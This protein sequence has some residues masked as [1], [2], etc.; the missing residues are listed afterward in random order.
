MNRKGE[1]GLAIIVMAF[2][3]ILVGVILF[4]A[5]EQEVGKSTTLINVIN[6]TQAWTVNTTFYISGYKVFNDVTITN[7]SSGHVVPAGNYTVTN[8]VLHPTS[9]ELTVSVIPNGGQD[10]V[11]EATG[12]WNV[13]SENAQTLTYVPESG[14]RSIA[15][16]IGIFFALAILIVSLSPTVRESLKFS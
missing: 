7:A 10:L 16:L 12:S 11:L 14:A 1:I 3:T 5:I 6:S 13:S 15:T 9:G 8:N 2:V 4:Q